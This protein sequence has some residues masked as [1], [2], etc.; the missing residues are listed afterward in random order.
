MAGAAPWHTFLCKNCLA[1]DVRYRQLVVDSLAQ[2]LNNILHFVRGHY[3][4][5]EANSAKLEGNCELRGTDNVQGPL[6][7]HSFKAKWRLLSLL[8]FKYFSQH[9]LFSH[10]MRLDQ[11]RASENISWI[12]RSYNCFYHTLVINLKRIPIIQGSHYL[13]GVILMVI[14]IASF[15]DNRF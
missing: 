2:Y 6:F 5:R 1:Y 10:A 9:A 7:E 12:I 3:L 13:E 11:S 15:E 14:H 4:F 8:S